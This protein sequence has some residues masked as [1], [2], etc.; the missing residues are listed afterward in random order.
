MH[1]PDGFVNLPTAVGFG[2]V[3]AGGVWYSLRRSAGLLDDRRI[4]LAGLMAAFL[5]AA[6]MVNFPVLSGTSGH[7]IGG[8]LAAVLIGPWLGVVA[9]T[10][11]LVVQGLF[12]AD[13]GIAALGLN[14]FNMALVGVLLGY[15]LYRT[16]L[17]ILPNV[18]WAVPAAAAVAAWASVPLA[19][20]GFVLQYAIGGEG[21]ASVG[22]VATA[23]V[24]VHLL[25]GIAEGAITALVVAAVLRTRPD[26]VSEAPQRAMAARH[27]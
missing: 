14:I 16:L 4:P 1:I 9:M 27:G 15:L 23:M 25:I 6:Q 11:V 5:F 10:V 26:L 20:S 22:T 7:L 21:S 24:G 12:F 18:R 13:G 3:S 17:V 8:V 2:G 19:A